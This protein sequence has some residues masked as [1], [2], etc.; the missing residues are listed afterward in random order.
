MSRRLTTLFDYEAFAKKFE[1]KKTTDDCYTP[2]AVFDAVLNWV[3]KE[4]EI[5]PETNVRPFYPDSDYQT[6]DYPDDCVVV[7]NPP[8]S[9]LK[10]IIDFYN[11][12]KIKYF[13]FAPHLTLFSTIEQN[14]NCVF[15]GSDI[16]YENNA[17][18]KTS[19]ITNL[20]DDYVRTAPDLAQQ[21]KE[22]Q[23]ENKKKLTRYEYPDQLITAS[24]LEK[25]VRRGID[26][27]LQKQD[28]IF[29]R[30]L[31]GQKAFGKAV[32][33][34]GLLIS[35]SKTQEYKQKLQEADQQPT[36]K[37]DTDQDII[38]ITLSQHEQQLIRDLERDTPTT[39]K[40]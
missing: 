25:L 29:I 13:L 17:N 35:D 31:D 1:P 21:I 39:H 32:F 18:V 22:A 2:P 38:T 20:G 8:F 5:N 36:N 30:R 27:R 16:I 19:F 7:D 9:I 34:A 28:S 12:H 33:G 10:Q 24:V 23:Q 14:T 40:P 15:T 26:F 3:V 11:Y 6:Y 4:Y 37:Q